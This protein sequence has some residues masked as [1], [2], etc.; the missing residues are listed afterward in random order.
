MRTAQTISAST[1]FTGLFLGLFGFFFI[2]VTCAVRVV[3]SAAFLSLFGGDLFL[4]SATC[5]VR[6]TA[7]AAPLGFNLLAG[8]TC[9]GFSASSTAASMSVAPKESADPYQASHA[10]SGNDLFKLFDLHRCLLID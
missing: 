5:A 8:T 6:F 4:I 9:A 2:S 7:S 10:Q 1:T 3:A